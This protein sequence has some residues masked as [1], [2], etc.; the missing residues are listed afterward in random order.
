MEV[1]ITIFTPTYNRKYKI[2]ELYT[3][4]KKQTNKEF[5]WVVVDDGSTDNTRDLILEWVEEELDFPIRYFYKD[6]GGKHSAINYGLEK[7]NGRLFIIVDSDDK[8]TKNAIDTILNVENSIDKEMYN[9]VGYGFN[10]GKS[11]EEIIGNTFSGESIIASSIDR[12]KYNI[13]GDKAEVFYTN[14]LKAYKFP[15]FIGEKF[16][17]ESVLW[18]KIASDGFNIKWFNKTIY[19]CEY[20]DD[21]LSFNSHNLAINNFVGYTFSIRE[22]LKYNLSIKEKLVLIGVYSKIGREKK[23]TYFQISKNIN[24]NI[25]LCFLSG[26]ASKFSRLLK[27]NINIMSKSKKQLK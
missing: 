24:Q 5:E 13:V 11:D 6:N 9:L 12:K 16:L 1:E 8:L 3:S 25:I 15:E 17:T 23:L 14:I 22:S 26:W 20:L 21:G 27:N 10:K 2:N 4:L 18:Y 19:L 7:A